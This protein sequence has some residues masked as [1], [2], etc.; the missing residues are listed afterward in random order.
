M[1]L[2]LRS[3]TYAPRQIPGTCCLKAWSASFVENDTE[4]ANRLETSTW[5]P[6]INYGKEDGY[7]VVFWGVARISSALLS[8]SCSLLWIIHVLRSVML[9][10]VLEISWSISVIWADWWSW[11]STA[12]FMTNGIMMDTVWHRSSAENKDKR[13]Q[14]RT[15]WD[16]AHL[17]RRVGIDTSRAHWLFC[18]GER[19]RQRQRH[20]ERGNFLLMFISFLLSF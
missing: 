1:V 16:T 8:L 14:Q 20:R 7:K 13:S 6:C 11:V 15:L 17:G 4:A 10:S 12:S 18:K 9:S 3:S 2:I 19:Q 5:L